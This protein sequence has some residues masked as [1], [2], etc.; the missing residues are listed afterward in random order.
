MVITNKLASGLWDTFMTK[1][2]ILRETKNRSEIRMCKVIINKKPYNMLE[3]NSKKDNKFA[4][5]TRNGHILVWIVPGWELLVD[6][7]II[8]KFDI[9]SNG[10]IKT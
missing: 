6:G 7:K 1:H 8:N 3:Q 2:S 10:Q 9:D 4:A 5:C